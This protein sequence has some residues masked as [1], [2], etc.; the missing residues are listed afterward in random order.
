MNRAAA[1]SLLG[2]AVPL[3]ESPS[4]KAAPTVL[5]VNSET[6]AKDSE[7]SE[8]K[9]VQTVAV[10]AGK[11]KASQDNDAGAKRHRAAPI[12]QCF[13]L[14]GPNAV[15]KQWGSNP[16]QQVSI[17]LYCDC[18][19]VNRT[20]PL[21]GNL[22]QVPKYRAEEVGHPLCKTCVK[23]RAVQL[24]RREKRGRAADRQ[25]REKRRAAERKHCEKQADQVSYASA[26]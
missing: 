7:A 17:H 18:S 15:H 4:Q 22:V 6:T 16:P 21:E 10:A 13:L 3:L 25:R 19:T 1:A 11:R 12:E 20:P 2:A 14:G 23:R 5:S 8:V 9:D 26:P 24:K